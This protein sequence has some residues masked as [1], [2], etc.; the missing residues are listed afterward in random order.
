MAGRRTI[1]VCRE[2]GYVSSNDFDILEKRFIN[3][4]LD[5]NDIIWVAW[6]YFKTDVEAADEYLDYLEILTGKKIN[7]EPCTITRTA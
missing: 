7:G 5:N 6:T 4:S 3:G 1:D 2:K